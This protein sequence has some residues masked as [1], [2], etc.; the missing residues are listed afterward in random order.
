MF[1]SISCSLERHRMATRPDSVVLGLQTARY[2]VIEKDLSR[3]R[4]TT[5]LTPQLIRDLSKIVLFRPRT[6]R[7]NVINR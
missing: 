6:S 2:R 1:V 5:S 3:M 4:R 7:E